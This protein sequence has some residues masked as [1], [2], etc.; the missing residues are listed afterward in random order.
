MVVGEV[1]VAVAGAMIDSAANLALQS[2]LTSR[3]K[4]DE[5]KTVMALATLKEFMKN[6]MDNC[7]RVFFS[8][9]VNT[10]Q[11]LCNSVA[12]EEFHTCYFDECSMQAQRLCT[13]GTGGIFVVYEKR[14]MGKSLA[15]ISLL[16]MRHGRAPQ[17]GV[18]FGG[19][20]GFESGDH[21]YASL[22]DHWFVQGLSIS[23]NPT[24]L[25]R[26][27]LDALPSD[28]KF[29]KEGK[30]SGLK[31]IP[32]IREHFLAQASRKPGG[33]PV[34]VFDDV[35]IKFEDHDSTLSPEKQMDNLRLSMGTA[36]TFFAALMSRAYERGVIIFVVTSSLL[37]AKYFQALNDGSKSRTFKKLTDTEGFTCQ[38]F[39]WST[40]KRFEFLKNRNSG[41]ATKVAE[42]V[43]QSLAERTFNEESTVR[44]MDDALTRLGIY[45]LNQAVDTHDESKDI[46]PEY[47]CTLCVMM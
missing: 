34:L 21:Y 30:A 6:K 2:I 36:H 9:E 39:G 11:R 40:E 31:E 38:K 19:S 3:D 4:S 7:S 17:R 46:D 44:E 29:L 41:N 47:N 23:F 24:I 28:L 32:S 22:L 16:T 43:L 37:V 45:P 42:R 27:I 25:A 15:A 14:G 10:N 12:V 1:T 18:Y 33:M 13:A 5:E 35:D 20:V 8:H 26:A